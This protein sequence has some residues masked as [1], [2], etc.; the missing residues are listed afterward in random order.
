[1]TVT[2]KYTFTI[3]ALD[4]DVVSEVLMGLLD[5]SL[6]LGTDYHISVTES[7]EGRTQAGRVV[8]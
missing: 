1:M 5:T 6:G 2:R 7:D 4:D 8:R 3:T